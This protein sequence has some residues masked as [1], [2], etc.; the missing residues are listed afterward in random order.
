MAFIER[1]VESFSLW[2]ARIAQVALA[3]VMVIIITNVLMR[4]WWKPLLG[5]HE[6]VEV[7][8]AVLL[9]LGIAYCAAKKGHVA[10]SI[11]VDKLSQKYQAVINSISNTIVLI[12]IGAISLEL[13]QYAHRMLERNYV[14]T[15]LSI[16]QYP[17]YYLVAFGILM[18]AVVL[19]LDL[20]KSIITISKEVKK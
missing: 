11:F 9:G 1:I 10:V 20:I 12:V 15:N 8:G 2:T 19:I 14:T 3:L 16:P 17:F 6:L 5:T 18:L 13:F 7:L 4:I